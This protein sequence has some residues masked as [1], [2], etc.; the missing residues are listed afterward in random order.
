LS[1]LRGW[2]LGQCVFFAF[3][4]LKLERD[5]PLPSFT[6]IMSLLHAERPALA[7]VSGYTCPPVELVPQ[8]EMADLIRDPAGVLEASQCGNPSLL[9][10]Q[11][12][13]T[14]PAAKVVGEAWEQVCG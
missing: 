6:R 10:E 14:R 2:P 7:D 11:L 12:K 8:I 5:W 1:P 4:A 13:D 9:L 3:L